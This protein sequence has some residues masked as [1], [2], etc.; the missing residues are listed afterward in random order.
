MRPTAKQVE[1]TRAAVGWYLHAHYGKVGDPGTV[2]MFTDASRLGPFAISRAALVEGDGRALFRLL[3]AVAMFQRRQD[4]QIAAILRSL[5]SDQAAELTDVDRLLAMVDASPCEHAKTTV[6]LAAECDLAKH[7]HTKQGLC[8]SHP[9]VACHLKLHTVWMRRYGHFG[10]VP[11][12]A[13]LVV[14]E[15]GARDL[16]ELLRRSRRG[17][18]GPTERAQAVADALS[19]SWRISDKISA[20][21]L[22]LIA[23]PDLTPGVSG[24]DD[25]DWRHFIVIDSNVDLFLAAI[26]YRGAKKYSARR[27][28]IRALSDGIDLRVLNPRMH[29]DNPRIVQQAM[30]LFMSA[31]NRRSLSHDCMHRRP[32]SCGACPKALAELCPVRDAP[33]ARRRL[34]V[35]AEPASRGGTQRAGKQASA[36]LGQQ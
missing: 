8:A 23:N 1:Q 35:I 30:F 20:M 28:F 15:S 6:S 19:R 9:D 2:S 17:V 11:T 16:A 12:S 31:S 26:R 32:A 3:V 33:L 18:R 5:S 27:A 14:R 36:A 10:K 29:R 21:F 4:V 22:S 25:L 7:P 34:P 24:W 13:A